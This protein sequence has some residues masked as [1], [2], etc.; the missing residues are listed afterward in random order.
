[1]FRALDL[2]NLAFFRYFVSAVTGQCC[3]REPR[4]D[5]KSHTGASSKHDFE[6]H[7]CTSMERTQIQTSRV[8]LVHLL[9]NCTWLQYGSNTD[10]AKA[11]SLIRTWFSKFSERG[12]VYK[13]YQ[14]FIYDYDLQILNFCWWTIDGFFAT[15]LDRRFHQK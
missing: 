7:L 4:G 6:F 8:W 14:A 11:P 13:W 12:R 15:H 3:Y 5:S 2:V 10:W 1:M 9:I